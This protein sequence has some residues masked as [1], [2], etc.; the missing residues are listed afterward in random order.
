MY[1][2]DMTADAVVRTLRRQADPE[3]GK[4]LARFFKTGPGE[5]AEG[6]RFWGIPVPVTRAA[7]RRFRN[8]PIKEI[9]R[10]LGHPVHEARV[11][12]V[13]LLA[14]RFARADEREQGRIYRLY[15]ANTRSINN[16]DLVD[17]SAPKIV[18]AWLLDRPK[19]MLRSLARSE[20]LWERRI[21][22][23]AT[24]AFISRG[25]SEDALDIAARLIND[26]HDLI[27]KAVGWML[28]EVGKRCSLEAERAFLD[29]HA[30]TMP[31][32]ALRYAIERLSP[33]ER[34]HYMGLKPVG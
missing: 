5:Y 13:I 8:L 34:R 24:L 29:R 9:E 21:A 22:M 4:V 14:D 31:R 15:L 16:W 17:L 1:E 6:D 20:N 32:T 3:R 7:L 18:G 33:G 25:E 26:R 11:A 12:A 27:H 23:V 2:T 30:A 10:L 28:R 19:G